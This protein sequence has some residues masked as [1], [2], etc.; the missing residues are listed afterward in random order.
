M[1][2]NLITGWTEDIDYILKADDVVVNLSGMTVAI[3]AKDQNGNAISMS[4]SLVIQDAA[5]GKVRF[6]PAAGDISRVQSDTY[7]VRW[8]VTDGSGKI[9]YFPNA[10]AEQWTIRD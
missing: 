2:A 10:G 7:Y 6:S 1:A 8:K 4:G 9:S 5:A 3:Q